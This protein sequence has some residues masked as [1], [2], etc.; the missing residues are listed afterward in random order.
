MNK[1]KVLGSVN[2]L[3]GKGENEGGND[4][5]YEL[6]RGGMKKT[7]KKMKIFLS[8]FFFVWA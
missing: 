6:R 3:T 5:T 2:V 4:R 8:L 7:E 1:K